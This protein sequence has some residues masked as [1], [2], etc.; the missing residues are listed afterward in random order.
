MRNPKELALTAILNSLE[1][2]DVEVTVELTALVEDLVNKQWES[3]NQD[4]DPNKDEAELL[5]L[6]REYVIRNPGNGAAH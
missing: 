6:I 1:E 4:R 2:A 5:K 3:R